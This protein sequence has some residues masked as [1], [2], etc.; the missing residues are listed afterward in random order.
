MP[1]HACG[2]ELI[3][4]KDFCH[5]CGEA[6]RR[7][8]AA[9]GARLD[10]DFRFCP[11]CG[12]P[13]QA[14]PAPA[15]DAEAEIGRFAKAMPAGM[16][17]KLSSTASIAGERKIVT[18]LFCDLAGSTAVASDLDPEEYRELLDQYLEI[19]FT[20]IYR[21][22]GIV[23]QLAGDGLMALFGAPI[24]HGDD[25]Q[26]AVWAGLA[27]R[28]AMVGFN[29]RIESERGFSLPARIGINTGPVVA[30]AV[31]NDLKMDYTAIGDTTNL[32]SRLESLAEPGTVLISAE[33][34]R[35]TRGFFRTQ[36]AGPFD[37]KGKDEAIDAFAVVEAVDATSSMAVAARRGLTHMVGRDEELAHLRSCFARL[38]G[39][40]P[41]LVHLVGVAGS[42]KSRLI[43]EL[44]R[45]LSSAGVTIFESHCSAL[46]QLEPYFPFVQMLR[47]YFAHDPNES[48]AAADRRI[49]E[50]IG[51]DLATVEKEFPHLSRLL[52]RTIADAT[53]LP[54]D[55]LQEET[56]R[57]LSSLISAE[58]QRAPVLA[59]IEDVQW[60]DEPSRELLDMALAKLVRARVM[61]IVSSRPER[62][63]LWRT[64]AALT[65]IPLRPLMQKE[66]VAIMRA[67]AGSPLPE[68][69]EARIGERAEGSPFF[70]EEITRSL[71]EGGRL[72]C[73][74]DGCELEGSLDEVE[75]PGSV[76]E[77]LAA[78]LDRLDAS[79]KRVA[80]LAAVLGR[81][82]ERS[83]I[84]EFL[85]SESAADTGA[86]IDHLVDRGVL[87]SV[88]DGRAFRF[89]ESLTQEVAYESLL[90]RERRQL[91]EQVA[92]LLER[93]GGR[94]TLIAHHYAR[95]SNR[96]KAL[97]SLLVAAKEAENL[98]AYQ[99]AIDLFR[100][101]WEIAETLVQSGAERTREQLQGLLDAASSYCRVVV[102]YGSS[103]DPLARRAAEV[104]LDVATELGDRDSM[105]T[106]KTFLG[107][108]LSATPASF[109]RGLAFVEA[110]VREAKALGNEALALS[111]SR[112][113]GW[114]Y[115]LDGRF[116]QGIQT[117]DWVL[118]RLPAA[119]EEEPVSDMYLSALSMREQVRF[120]S[121]DV[122]GAYRGNRELMRLCDGAGN[123]TLGSGARGML[124]YCEL[125][126]ANYERAMEWAQESF[127]ISEEIGVVWGMRRSAI[128]IVAA[129]VEI[130][131]APPSRRLRSLAE[132][133]MNPGS[134]MVLSAMPLIEGMVALLKFSQA[135]RLARMAVEMSA[136]RLRVMYA[137]AALGDAT[138]RLGERVWAESEECFRTSLKIAEEIECSV[139]QVVCLN[140]LGKLALVR[141]ERSQAE[142]FLETSIAI[143][144]PAGIERYARRAERLLEEV[145][146]AGGEAAS[147]PA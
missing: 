46:H 121:G 37:V 141:G 95:S 112:A 42:G 5:A 82:F 87:R 34:E 12:A 50:K 48:R 29:Q 53:E 59:I 30:G 10:G 90:L 26:R 78:R 9:C 94:A 126:R 52:S 146:D 124:A 103:E 86:A 77:V 17:E 43:Y 74:A 4:G 119:G 72:R 96:N 56:N 61:L 24:T 130:S 70:V 23:N 113:L 65:R 22:E 101:A 107:M 137:R 114:N 69:V 25:P 27:I 135:E 44:K 80:Q 98:P 63:I 20:E 39:R 85:G 108:T 2:A 93:R 129:Q 13:V 55:E 1:C 47:T 136:G 131:D 81:Q 49:A 35:L 76:R 84:D 145:R 109:D 97:E 99:S 123:R 140:G 68:Q 100:Q 8:C 110:G 83:E 115:L 28:D 45:E 79:A 91:H 57:A 64:Q 105:A 71:I 118:D 67:L 58:S 73:D 40:L 116:E 60:L 33:T 89:G 139:G 92:D 14:A 6:V 127:A 120:F 31:G 36:A 15:S 106:A 128:L 142:R 32:A 18:V 21:F 144:R 138:L 122:E 132:E 125:L 111:T 147:I 62:E 51:V 133:G 66:M 88:E 143:S 134:N 117:Y 38:D 54:R 104:S 102:L 19:A 11:D 41:Q 3:A 7:H 75:I 16:A